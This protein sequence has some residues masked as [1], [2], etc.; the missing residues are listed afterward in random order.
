MRARLRYLAVS[1]RPIRL[2]PGAGYVVGLVLAALA[3][4]AAMLASVAALAFVQVLCAGIV[5]VTA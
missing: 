4:V 3:P 5:A 2:R 1:P